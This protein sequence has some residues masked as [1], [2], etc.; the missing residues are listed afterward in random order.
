MWRNT[1]QRLFGPRGRLSG[2]LEVVDGLVLRVRVRP[3][4]YRPT[5]SLS[6]IIDDV[7]PDAYYAQ[8]IAWLAD[9]GATTGTSPTTFSPDDNVTR[10]QLA[11]FLWRLDQAGV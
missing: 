4:W 5:G 10:G 11:T 6:F 7:D 9:T 3:D 8:P 2:Q 1:V